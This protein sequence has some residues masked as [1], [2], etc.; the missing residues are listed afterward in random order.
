M[1]SSS[2]ASSTIIVPLRKRLYSGS[3]PMRY[4]SA[5][6]SEPVVASSS[7]SD[8]SRPA[9]PRPCSLNGT[10]G[11]F[12]PFST[13]HNAL[14]SNYFNL[15]LPEKRT[16]KKR[17]EV[18][19]VRHYLAVEGDQVRDERPPTWRDFEILYERAEEAMGRGDEEEAEL[20]VWNR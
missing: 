13:I 12:L 9:P 15:C 16:D 19:F 4:R 10:D 2:S 1:S 3:P 14:Q 20:I 8:V 11:I 7:R 18:D 17:P 5:R 6:N